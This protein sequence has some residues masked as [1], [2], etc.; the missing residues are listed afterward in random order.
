MTDD[1]TPHS[2]LEHI[3]DWG[4]LRDPDSLRYL[5]ESGTSLGFN[6]K[7]DPELL[8]R[9]PGTDPG[10]V[11][12]DL[13]IARFDQ[14]WPDVDDMSLWARI[15]SDLLDLVADE[16]EILHKDNGPWKKV[17]DY[18]LSVGQKRNWLKGF[19]TQLP[20][21]SSED[22]FR[23][24]SDVKSGRIKL[25]QQHT[26]GCYVATAVYGDYDSPEVRI[27]RRFRDQALGTSAAGRG[28][29]QT[30]YAASPVLLKT[31]DGAVSRRTFRVAL[32]RLVGHLRR[33]GY[34]DAAYSDQ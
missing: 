3:A 14:L 15:C 10:N 1:W 31:F 12:A 6:I 26:G 2:L 29:I 30:Y 13:L 27:L 24:N 19:A 33:R 34:S 25:P 22:L 20:G 4:S 21:M 9:G 18:H 23:F 5:G 17:L 28:L 16:W 8:P 11:G 32:D 7:M